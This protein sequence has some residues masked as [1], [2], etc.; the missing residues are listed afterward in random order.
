MRRV[1]TEIN[2][3]A[4]VVLHIVTMFL[5]MI[6]QKMETVM[7]VTVSNGFKIIEPPL[8]VSITKSSRTIQILRP[9]RILI[10]G[11]MVKLQ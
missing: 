6:N 10:V 11:R 8:S 5:R 4:E 2:Q 9:S 1:A 7:R 3:E